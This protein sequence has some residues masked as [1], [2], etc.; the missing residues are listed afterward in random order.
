LE[1]SLVYRTSDRTDKVAQKDPVLKK[2]KVIV[3][4]E[5]RKKLFQLNCLERT[6][7][8]LLS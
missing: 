2:K 6:L 7:P 3:E 1:D 5:A 4:A 8:N